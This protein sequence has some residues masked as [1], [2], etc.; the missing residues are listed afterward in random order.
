MWAP[1]SQF[2][3]SFEEK[4]PEKRSKQ[5]KDESYSLVLRPNKTRGIPET[6]LV[7]SLCLCGLFCPHLALGEDPPD[8]DGALHVGMAG[9]SYRACPVQGSGSRAYLWPDILVIIVCMYVVHELV[10]PPVS[11]SQ[12]DS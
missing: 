5:Q 6:L 7:G 9:R 2:V 4:G 10:S 3:S 11:L 1:T 8:P 12:F